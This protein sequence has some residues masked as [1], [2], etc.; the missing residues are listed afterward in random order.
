MQAPSTARVMSLLNAP[1]PRKRIVFDDLDQAVAAYST[2]IGRR[3][4][5]FFGAA[6]RVGART[7]CDERLPLVLVDHPLL[8]EDPIRP[9]KPRQ[10]LRNPEPRG[11]V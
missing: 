4:K 1:S 9:Q 6:V 8:H 11:Y 5:A 3:V 2:S 7:G 10:A